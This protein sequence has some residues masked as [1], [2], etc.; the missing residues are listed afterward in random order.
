MLSHATDRGLTLSPGTKRAI[1]KW[2]LTLR[3]AGS[4][5]R[6]VIRS[7]K[8][9]MPAK[10]AFLHLKILFSCGF[11]SFIY[12]MQLNQADICFNYMCITLI[13]N[14]SFTKKLK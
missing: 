4:S 14:K 6:S 2:D 11:I 10:R 5:N 13:G 8:T 7:V 9:K 12:S 3:G 1:S